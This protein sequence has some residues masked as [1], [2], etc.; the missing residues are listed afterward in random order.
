MSVDL[1]ELQLAA[2]VDSGELLAFLS[3]NDAIGA[4]ESDGIV[5]VYW[6]RDRWSPRVVED[7][8]FALRRLGIDWGEVD[9]RIHEVVDRDWNE[10]WMKSIHPVEIGG[11]I[12]IRQS[13]NPV[14]VRPG[15]AE[16]I[17]DPKR[18]FG[19][20]YHATTRLLVEWIADEICGGERVLDI[21]TGS[22][23]LAMTALR[24]GAAHAVGIDNDES[25]VECARENALLNGFGEE[26][27]LRVGSVADICACP[28]DL[29]VAN[30]DRRTLLEISGRLRENL[31]ESGKALLSGLLEE[32]CADLSEVLGASGGRV[33][34]KRTGD[35]WVALEVRFS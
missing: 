19:S 22:G 27:E 16:L 8:E 7:F 11:R 35:E 30:L 15:L 24:C 17:I 25:A 13:W 33:K 4:W 6:P 3:S 31:I 9:I 14:V 26:L 29:I 34:G 12:L 18:A 23:I 2:N 1:I 32:D 21:G 20:G 28:F 10:A 5:H